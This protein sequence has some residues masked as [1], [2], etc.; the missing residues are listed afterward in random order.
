MNS[1]QHADLKQTSEL[2]FTYKFHYAPA[3]APAARLIFGYTDLRNTSQS[4]QGVE[5]IRRGCSKKLLQ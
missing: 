1:Q 5:E 3:A 4:G 2:Y